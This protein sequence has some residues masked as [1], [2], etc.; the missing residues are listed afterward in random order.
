MDTGLKIQCTKNYS[1]EIRWIQQLNTVQRRRTNMKIECIRVTASEGLH[2]KNL[3]TF[4]D[5]AYRFDCKIYVECKER[6]SNARSL[7]GMLALS[8]MQSDDIKLI[9]DGAD[10]EIAAKELKELFK[11]NFLD[12]KVVDRIRN[13]KN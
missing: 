4:I 6:R 3:S 2:G 10:E 7:M 5:C 9:M 1:A 12:K 13:R 11:T 8:V